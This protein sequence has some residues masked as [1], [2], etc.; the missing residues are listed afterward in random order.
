[1]KSIITL[2][3]LF[4]IFFG[5]A[6]AQVPLPPPVINDYK[7]LTSYS[8]LTSY[9]EL[10]GKQSELMKTE[11]IGQSV[12]GRNLYA[13]KFSSSEFGRDSSK[14][15]VLIFAQQHGNEQSGKES[16]LLLS[17][18]LLKPENRYLFDKIDL[19][20]IPQVN[21]DGSELNKRRNASGFDLNRNHLIL[22]EPETIAL[23]LLFD[24]FLFEVTLD[25][26]EYSPYSEEWR[27]YG[28]RKNFDIN[29]GSTSNLNVAEGIRSLSDNSC[30]PFIFSY[31]NARNFSSFTYCPGGPPEIAYIRHSTFDIND[32]RQSFGIQGTFSFIQ[33]G[34][35]GKD[36]SIENL[37]HRAE[38][39]MTGM[40]ALL[41][42]VYLNKH[43]IKPLVS[44][45]RKK[46]VS[47]DPGREISIQSVH[48]SNGQSLQIPLYSYY[49]EADSLVTVKDYR[50]VVK[51][52]YD[53]LKPTG[54]LIPKDCT[55]LLE[56]ARRHSLEQIL[57]KKESNYQYVQHLITL[58]D[59][60]DFEGDTVV[61]PQ[62]TQKVLRELPPD[63]G[64]IFIPTAQL[65]GTLVVLALEPKSMLGLVT[66][67]QYASL[68]KKGQSFPVLRVNKK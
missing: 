23:H 15:K 48:T 2:L 57:L 5:V 19:V 31:L 53:V 47:F 42:Y 22:T 6:L 51:S 67:K 32:G 25:V 61:D 7:K 55:V 52:V 50:P 45:E 65:K 56:W 36:D 58:I 26:H 18:E 41:E 24:R 4:Q 54:Y 44:K 64:F 60:I 27:K 49:S 66:Y 14:I 8:E 63:P 12:K 1:M 62:L 34:M 35:N 16:V 11:I 29:I 46:L 38:G 37:Q 59:S 43:R 3:T 21:P 40:R 39:Q 68:L 10:L 17:S 20:I 13:L 30:L 28:Y 33:E 9:V